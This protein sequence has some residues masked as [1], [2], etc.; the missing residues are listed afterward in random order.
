[1]PRAFAASLMHSGF[2]TATV[3][4]PRVDGGIVIILWAM[5]SRSN[6]SIA[7]AIAIFGPAY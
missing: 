2:L 1:M 7:I 5:S 4:G 6:V 3:P